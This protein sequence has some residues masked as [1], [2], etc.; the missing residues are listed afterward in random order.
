M[1]THDHSRLPCPARRRGMAPLE[2]V[3]ALPILLLMMV[4]IVWL[5]FFVI[6][7]TEVI[8]EARNKAWGKRF[9]NDKQVPLM[10]PTA[11]GDVKNPEYAGD[12]DYVTE[13]ATTKVDVSPVFAMVPG[14]RSSHMILAGSWDYRVMK[15]DKPPDWNL[16]KYALVNALTGKLQTAGAILNNMSELLTDIVAQ[17][18]AAAAASLAG[19]GGGGGGGGGG[20]FD[21]I[22]SG[23]TPQ[24]DKNERPADGAE[25][26]R[27]AQLK[28][29][30]D[31]LKTE[32]T[33]VE[34]DLERLGDFRTGE[35]KEKTQERQLLQIK[36][37]RIENHL[38][39]LDK[40]ISD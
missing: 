26:Q 10:F 23:P 36:L 33:Q 1:R 9:E 35:P 22:D 20:G 5:G 14:P 6:G 4:G 37:D 3:M 16:V 28:A 18:A 34:A 15:F 8:I 30:R 38:N 24:P 21:G 11:L 25:D 40:E 27:E 19:A 12:A 13:E 32:K 7:Q 2:F 39:Y 17:A 29:D 31:R